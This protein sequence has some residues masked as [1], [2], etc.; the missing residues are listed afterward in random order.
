MREARDIEETPGFRLPVPGGYETGKWFALSFEDAVRW[1]R[2][3]QRF[4]VSA[5]PFRVVAV[6]IPA[7]LLADAE[8]RVRLDAIGPAYF[9]PIDHLLT[10]NR[11]GSTNIFEPVYDVE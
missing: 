8:F 4:V 7:A 6:Q 1:G 2:S 9:L 3:M 5:V 10:L 11:G